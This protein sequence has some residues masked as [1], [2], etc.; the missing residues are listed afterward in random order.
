MGFEPIIQSD[1]SWKIGQS[2]KTISMGKWT[3]RPKKY[4]GSGSYTLS[5]GSPLTAVPAGTLTN[6][7]VYLIYFQY[8]ASGNPWI[9]N[10]CFLFSPVN[11]NGAQAGLI[12]SVPFICHADNGSTFSVFLNSPTG[13][14]AAGGVNIEVR[15]SDG[16]VGSYTVDV[17]DM[18]T[19]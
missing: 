13:T 15:G 2:G 3:S 8:S 12:N 17:Y 5:T 18:G 14:T 19:L 4:A 16:R 11:M 6:G 7:N 10:V 1:G 9:L